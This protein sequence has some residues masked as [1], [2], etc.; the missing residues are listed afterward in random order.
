MNFDLVGHN[1]NFKLPDG[2]EY[3]KTCTGGFCSLTFFLILL[4]YSAA[5]G[6]QFFAKDVYTIVKRD[7]EGFY[8]D[9]NYTFGYDNGF[10]VAAGVWLNPESL[11]ELD[12]EINHHEIGQTKFVMKYWE[13][14]DESVKFRDMK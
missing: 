1:F 4:A 13:V 3:Y 11:S 8:L 9:S 5:T 6:V 12:P 14:L 7:T 10:A 2:E